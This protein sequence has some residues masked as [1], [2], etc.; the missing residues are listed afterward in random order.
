MQVLRRLAGESKARPDASSYLAAYMLGLVCH[1]GGSGVTGNQL[2]SS[3]GLEF[4]AVLVLLVPCNNQAAI[5][6]SFQVFWRSH[7]RRGLV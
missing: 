4:L 1:I 3:R 2:S 5:S 6:R 7:P